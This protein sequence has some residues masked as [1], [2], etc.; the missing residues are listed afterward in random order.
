MNSRI[1]VLSNEDISFV[2]GAGFT[3]DIKDLWET[4]MPYV[5]FYVVTSALIIAG[6]LICDRLMSRTMK[7][8][9]PTICSPASSSGHSPRNSSMTITYY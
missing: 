7:N 5:K 4:Y 1:V 2:S 8:A 6:L 9:K 3:D